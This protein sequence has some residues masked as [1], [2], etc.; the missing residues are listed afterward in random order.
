MS[1]RKL[2]FLLYVL[3]FTSVSIASEI[4]LNQN[5][6]NEGIMQLSLKSGDTPSKL[7]YVDYIE[8]SDQDFLIGFHQEMSL[9]TSKYKY[10]DSGYSTPI[11]AIFT[12]VKHDGTVDTSYNSGKGYLKLNIG[13]LMAGIVNN[14]VDNLYSSSNAKIQSL[15]RL[16]DDKILILLGQALNVC[17]TSALLVRL[18][19]NGD[20]DESFADKGKLSIQ[21]G[22]DHDECSLQEMYFLRPVINVISE[23]EV[24]IKVEKRWLEHIDFM[25]FNYSYKVIYTDRITVNMQ[26]ASIKYNEGKNTIIDTILSECDVSVFTVSR[27]AIQCGNSLY[28]VDNR[29]TLSSY[30]FTR[31]TLS[32]DALSIVNTQEFT[33]TDPAVFDTDGNIGEFLSG[34][35][36][37]NNKNEV[38]ALTSVYTSSNASPSP[39]YQD[40]I[41][42]YV[43]KLTPMGEPDTSFADKGTIS[44]HQ[45]PLIRYAKHINI[46]NDDKLILAGSNFIAR[47]NSDL[48]LDISFDNQGKINFDSQEQGQLNEVKVLENDNLVLTFRKPNQINRLTLDKNGLFVDRTIIPFGAAIEHY[49]DFDDSLKTLVK[50]TPLEN[51]HLRIALEGHD[52]KLPNG[53]QV[54]YMAHIAIDEANSL[55]MEYGTDGIGAKE[56]TLSD[57]RLSSIVNKDGSVLSLTTEGKVYKYAADG[58]LDLN[59][60]QNGVYLLTSSYRH[61]LQQ[62]DGSIL[63][64]SEREETLDFHKIDSMGKLDT[65]FGINGT[66]YLEKPSNWP[67]VEAH[68]Q[69]TRLSKNEVARGGRNSW[70]HFEQ[71]ENDGF[72]WFIS[73]SKLSADGTE[74]EC[75]YGFRFGPNAEQQMDYA[76]SGRYEFCVDS[77]LVS[78]NNDSIKVF[79]VPLKQYINGDEEV[80]VASLYTAYD[81]NY[82]TDAI[83]KSCRLLF[84]K[85]Q[86]SSSSNS[87]DFNTGIVSHQYTNLGYKNECLRDAR[88]F[89][90]DQQPDG[91]TILAATEGPVGEEDFRLTRLNK[92]GSLDKSFGENGSY[93]TDFKHFGMNFSGFKFI[94]NSMYF[95]GSID[96]DLLILNLQE[97]NHS[98]TLQNKQS[99]RINLQ[100]NSVSTVQT[101]TAEDLDK[102]ELTWSI[103]SSPK[104]GKVELSPSNTELS[105]LYRPDSNFSGTDTFEITVQDWRGAKDMLTIDVN[106]DSLSSPPANNSKTSAGGT[107]Y[108][109][110]FFSML[111]L[112]SRHTRF[113]INRIGFT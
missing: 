104:H 4:N 92:D 49:P 14:S 72:E 93:L 2:F 108:L 85:K 45:Q 44:H 56:I 28:H 84:I 29:Y 18:M 6:G 59:F 17:Q 69:S 89:E 90:I 55:N 24:Q 113:I 99:E 76:Q 83:Y 27:D 101:L 64:F 75:F 87:Q 52:H 13:N 98:P 12:R 58:L 112:W 36:V 46:Q 105:Y 102:D 111:V 62:P 43:T 19:P 9:T 10:E 70:L 20:L 68:R 100:E 67:A 42:Y 40:S 37:S 97:K 88:L 65:N 96:S 66:K 48:S 3:T 79:P 81:D 39:S 80:I 103:S 21:L 51:G 71:L 25:Q 57:D 22:S 15:H 91:K 38:Y 41:L 77:N 11:H 63:L 82:F 50:V 73:G 35:L 110:I 53:Y 107:F 1:M 47:F 32:G 23:N 5:F 78:P 95:T 34:G 60:A 61:M 31:H 26:D 54:S 30:N 8:L 109:L 7:S 94:K 33:F 16:E 74:Q 106:V 86:K